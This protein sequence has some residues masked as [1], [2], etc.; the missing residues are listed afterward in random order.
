[1]ETCANIKL[2][3]F[4]HVIISLKKVIQYCGIWYGFNCGGFATMFV[5]LT[6]FHIY[7]DEFVDEKANEDHFEE[8]WVVHMCGFLTPY[9]TIP[10]VEEK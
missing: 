3:I 7:G 10:N 6:Y 2:S 4:L 9:D 5:D 8:P 1:M